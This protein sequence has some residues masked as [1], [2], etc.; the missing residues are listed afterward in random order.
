MSCGPRRW[1]FEFR[2]ANLTHFGGMVLV[3]R[4]CQKLRLRWRFQRDVLPT[5]KSFH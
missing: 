1:Q 5:S 3:Q 4:F 2:D